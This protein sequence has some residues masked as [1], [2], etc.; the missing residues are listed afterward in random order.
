MARPDSGPTS[1]YE[2]QIDQHNLPSS[3]EF[4]TTTMTAPSCYATTQALLPLHL[5]PV[6]PADI[7]DSQ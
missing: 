7:T 3:T 2:S 4:Q 6:D 5:D 1:R